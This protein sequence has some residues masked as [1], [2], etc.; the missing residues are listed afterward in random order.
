M[1]HRCESEPLVVNPGP[2]DPIAGLAVALKALL[3]QGNVLHFVASAL[4][5]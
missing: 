3:N 2:L 1:V 4:L 5:S